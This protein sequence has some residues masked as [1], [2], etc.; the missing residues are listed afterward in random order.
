MQ[1]SSLDRS[2]HAPTPTFMIYIDFFYFFFRILVLQ[3]TFLD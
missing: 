2:I 1:I 3:T